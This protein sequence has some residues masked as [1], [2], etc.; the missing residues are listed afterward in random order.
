MT[1]AEYSKVAGVNWSTLKELR[2]SPLHYQHRLANP[3]ED[4]T[5]LMLGRGCHTSI[6]EP[7]RFAL[8]YAVF[9]G[10]RRAGKAWDAFK[11]LHAADDTILKVD[12]YARCLAMRDAVR[13][14]PIA[15]HYLTGGEAEKSIEWA[16]R[17]TGLPCKGRIDYAIK[18]RALVD[19]KGTKD[20]DAEQFAKLAHR[21]GYFGQAAF[22]RDGWTT[23]HDETLAFVVI[24]VEME[25]PHDVA[26]FK[27][28]EDSLYAG[29]EEVQALLVRAAECQR[30]QQWPGRYQEEQTLRLPRWAWDDESDT[31]ATGLDLVIS[32][33]ANG[34]TP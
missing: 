32:G 21:M 19:V 28:D 30:T 24:A 4:T 3:R 20:V 12:E 27:L 25:P 22:Y 6:L 10:P 23:V 18:G 16:D 14:H 8:E 13:R 15:S 31:D 1:Y 29:Y 5:R 9:K 7:D 11:E 26:V 17:L 34:G 2:R 33:H